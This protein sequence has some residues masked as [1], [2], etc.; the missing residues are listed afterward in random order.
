MATRTEGGLGY[1]FGGGN[2]ALST[3]T[4]NT[5]LKHWWPLL[6]PKNAFSLLLMSDRR[7]AEQAY[8]TNFT[9]FFA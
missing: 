9:Y 6:T 8:A 4:M 7:K 1:E 2:H 3:T 5:H